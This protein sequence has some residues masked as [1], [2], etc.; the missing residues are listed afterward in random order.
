[1]G[2]DTGFEELNE[3]T[4]GWQETK[5]I[6]V[7]ARPGMGKTSLGMSFARSACQINR[8]PVGIFSLDVSEDDL[9]DKMICFET[10]MYEQQLKSTKTSDAIFQDIFKTA[11][12]YYANDR[13]TPLIH[14][15][16][17]PVSFNQL[18][19][20]AHRWKNKHDIKLLVVDFLQKVTYDMPGNNHNRTQ[21]VDKVAHGLKSL[22][23]ELKIPVISLCQLNRKVEE[24]SKTKR[25]NL[26]HLKEAGAIEE[27]ADIIIFPFRPEYYKS[28]GMKGFDFMNLGENE[29]DIECEGKAELIIAKHR[30]GATKSI[31]VNFEKYTTLFHC[32][33]R[34]IIRIG[35]S[36]S[37]LHQQD[38]VE[39]EQT[40]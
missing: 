9:T 1:M 12:T 33:C 23:K 18:R 24:E 21:E 29:T 14:I 5:H 25:P 30:S 31:I 17:K 15:H 28:Q 10:G 4:G 22:A 27:S 8:V 20:I 32:P 40:F 16:D 2:L 3:I 39:G 11:D 37:D 13:S 36:I 35:T 38:L 6:I 19:M 26:S 7:A 34:E